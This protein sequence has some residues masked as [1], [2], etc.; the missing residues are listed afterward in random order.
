MSNRK[1]EDAVRPV[2]V[3]EGR[4]LPPLTEDE[5]SVLDVLEQERGNGP[6]SALGLTRWIRKNPGASRP[7]KGIVAAAERL[8]AGMLISKD[9][10]DNYSC[11]ER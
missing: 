5:R 9:I 1:L 3:M 4:P 8:W 7:D 10:E 6:L 11:N 2:V